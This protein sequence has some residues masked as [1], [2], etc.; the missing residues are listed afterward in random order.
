M[1]RLHTVAAE[2]TRRL[3]RSAGG[4]P[5]REPVLHH[6]CSNAWVAET[7]LSHRS[8]PP[9]RSG[10]AANSVCTPSA[11]SPGRTDAAKSQTVAAVATWIRRLAVIFCA[12]EIHAPAP[13][14]SESIRHSGQRA[15]RAYC[16]ACTFHLSIVM[17]TFAARNIIPRP[18]PLSLA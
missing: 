1:V 12:S 3:S 15:R 8:A 5:R 18:V 16:A 7:S 14:E 10:A 11:T 6:R 2:S 17:T 9:C 13:E 4:S